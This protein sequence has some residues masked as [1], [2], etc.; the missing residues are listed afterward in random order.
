[1]P[2][3]V[4]DFIPDAP[5]SSP[6]PISSDGIDFIPSGPVPSDGI[7]FQ[8]DQPSHNEAT[9]SAKQSPWVSQFLA[10]AYDF[11]KPMIGGP[12]GKAIVSAGPIGEAIRSLPLKGDKEKLVDMAHAGLVQGLNAQQ[13]IPPEGIGQNLARGAGFTIAASPILGVLSAP[14]SIIGQA[15]TWGLFSAEQAALKEDATMK[16]VGKETLKGAIAGPLL[17]KIG[18]AFPNSPLGVVGSALSQAGTMLGVG[19]AIDRKVPSGQEIA[20]QSIF[21]LGLNAPHFIRSSIEAYKKAG[22][23]AKDIA[24]LQEAEKIATQI[25]VDNPEIAK[26]AKAVFQQASDVA[27]QSTISKPS[28]PSP[29]QGE[30]VAPVNPSETTIEKKPIYNTRK[31]N[32]AQK[33][34]GERFIALKEGLELVKTSVEEG[35]PGYRQGVTEQGELGPRRIIG[36]VKVPSTYPKWFKNRGLTAKYIINIIDKAN[37]G[38]NLTPQQLG[39]LDELLGYAEKAQG[40]LETEMVTDAFKKGVV[41]KEGVKLEKVNETELE[42]GQS[43]TQHG[44]KYEVKLNSEGEK[45][46]EDG[47]IIKLDDFETIHID[48]GSLSKPLT[49][50]GT[51]A[52]VPAEENPYSIVNLAENPPA[53]EI[54]GASKNPKQANAITSF[55][56]RVFYR[57]GEMGEEVAQADRQRKNLIAQSL[58]DANQRISKPIAE[59]IKANPD[60]SEGIYDYLKGVAPLP[61]GLP[62]EVSQAAT[63]GRQYIDGLSKKIIAE[64]P[65]MPETMQKTI[66]DNLAS[67][68]ARRY[69]LYQNPKFDPENISPEHMA[70]YA[71]WLKE[72]NPEAFKSFTADEMIQI[73]KNSLSSDAISIKKGSKEFTLS[74]NNLLR[75]KAIPQDIRENIFGEIK[76][77]AWVLSNTITDTAQS[78]HNAEFLGVVRKLDGVVVRASYPGAVQVPDDWKRWGPLAG[79]YVTPKT[80]KYLNDTMGY[81]KSPLMQ[82]IRKFAVTPFKYM[83]VIMN[84]PTHARQIM[85]NEQLKYLYGTEITDPSNAKYIPRA[86]ASL[87]DDAKYSELIK[88]GA[89]E[90]GFINNEIRQQARTYLKNPGKL[91]EYIAGDNIFNRIASKPG[92]LFTLED[93]LPKL[94]YY[95][96]MLDQGMTPAEA[97]KAT[98]EHWPNFRDVPKVTR[99]LRD[100]PVAGRFVSFRSEIIRIGLLNLKEAALELSKG[101]P[102]RALR[103]A[104]VFY[105][106]EAARNV[107]MKAYNIDQKELDKYESELEVWTRRSG[108][109]IYWRDEKGNIKSFDAS[110]IH[111]WGDVKMAARALAQGN[112]RYSTDMLWNSPEYGLLSAIKTG[113]DPFT[114]RPIT[115]PQDPAM[116]KV[117]DFFSYVADLYNLP[118]LGTKPLVKSLRGEFSAGKK[119]NPSAEATA[120]LT[121]IRIKELDIPRAKMFKLIELQDQAKQAA[122]DVLR[123]KNTNPNASPQRYRQVQEEYINRMEK[124]EKQMREIISINLNKGAAK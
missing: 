85:T 1:M 58:F 116:K 123:F 66:T 33:V 16:D 78:A 36:G 53:F 122:S 51:E 109:S 64:N 96:K 22:A 46:V 2:E 23:S 20:T 5:A 95:E 100:V 82:G 48:K 14:K 94:I 93:E 9:E 10:G 83:R 54:T 121:G 39:M 107:L 4:I 106:P 72:G 26:Q 111:P 99:V 92:Q 73:A 27:P 124:I 8:P 89:A 21:F 114:K 40:G 37:A 65:N 31:A 41:L 43:F 38:K 61:E 86:L 117:S 102:T 68:T 25:T 90:S 63:F 59:F 29:S 115:H 45:I 67:Y 80:F 88:V 28:M 112:W 24:P 101:D 104:T 91:R 110:F 76:D 12:V 49:M 55:L 75:R 19:A 62:T 103:F 108:R 74:A 87:A 56:K 18:K 44:E 71:A 30:I 98:Q 3:D 97:G 13:S 52:F 57:G 119:I 60:H 113:E 84:W 15:M 77:P 35:S 34:F 50:L 7:D 42:P 120:F 79:E 32:T 69:E 70:R 118:Y 47:Q 81:Q 11:L 105:W 17:M 6:T